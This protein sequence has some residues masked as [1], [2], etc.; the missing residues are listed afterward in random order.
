MTMKSLKN[1]M[2]I[3]AVYPIYNEC[4]HEETEFSFDTSNTRKIENFLLINGITVFHGVCPECQ[5]EITE[6]VTAGIFEIEENEVKTKNK[7]NKKDKIK[8]P[9]QYEE[10]E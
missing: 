8:F 10:Y 6:I 2:K 7:K 9:V 3:K 4:Q 1:S 5:E